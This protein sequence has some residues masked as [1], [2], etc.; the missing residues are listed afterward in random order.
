MNQSTPKIMLIQVGIDLKAATFI[1]FSHLQTNIQN[2][3]LYTYIS[4]VLDQIR[5]GVNFNK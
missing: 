4:T 3:Q 1:K 5:F 2:T